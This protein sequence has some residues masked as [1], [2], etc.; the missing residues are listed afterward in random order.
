[1]SDLL[2]QIREPMEQH[3][4]VLQKLTYRTRLISSAFINERYRMSQSHL[5]LAQE[6]VE[7]AIESGYHHQVSNAKRQFGIVA[8]CANQLD[9]AEAAFRE[10]ISLCK[11]NGDMNSML[12]ARTYLSITHRRQRKLPEVR[13]DTDLL[14]QELE[15][16]SHNPAY[17]GVVHAN[18]AWLAYQDGDF[19]SA[20]KL[21]QSALKVWQK[22]EN[23]YPLHSLASFLIFA[24]AVQEQNMDEAFT[25]AHAMLA[26][27]EWKLTLKVESALLA[28]LEANPADKDLSLRLCREVVELAKA[29]GYL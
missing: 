24:L 3:G 7:L 12:I 28:T 1:V 15:K 14:E 18:R 8:L 13:T 26:P 5:V 21:A 29:A 19:H 9:V 16:A 4:T 22:L 25:C 10:T 11:Q 6:T 17:R 27:P 2:E 20:Q 23:P